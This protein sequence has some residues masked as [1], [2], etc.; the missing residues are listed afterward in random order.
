MHEPADKEKAMLKLYAVVLGGKLPGERLGEDHET[1][2]VVAE[3]EEL[4]RAQA[5]AKWSGVAEKGLHID[6]LKCVEQV[7]GYAVRLAP[8]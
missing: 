7:D 6:A 3:S 8:I 2:F 5:K 1:V 4:A